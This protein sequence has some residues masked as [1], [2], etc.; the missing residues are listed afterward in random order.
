MKLVSMI[1]HSVCSLFSRFSAKITIK[2][3]FKA[4]LGNICSDATLLFMYRAVLNNYF[5]NLQSLHAHCVQE[6]H[7]TKN[8]R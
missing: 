8:I 6:Q 2:N 7:I 3:D 1:S 5:I 4:I